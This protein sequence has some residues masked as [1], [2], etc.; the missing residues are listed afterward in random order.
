MRRRDFLAQAGATVSPGFILSS[1]QGF[2][3]LALAAGGDENKTS[4]E[5]KER[6]GRRPRKGAIAKM[7][8]KRD[9]LQFSRQRVQMPKATAA[10]AATREPC[11]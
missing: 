10:G 6:Q 3:N 5:Q 8:S 7:T 2:I 1:S 11:V 9:E 4:L